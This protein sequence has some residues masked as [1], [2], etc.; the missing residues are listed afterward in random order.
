M[1]DTHME[2]VPYVHIYSTWATHY[3]QGIPTTKIA[4]CTVC[5]SAHQCQATPIYLTSTSCPTLSTTVGEK[6]C[7][8]MKQHQTVKKWSTDKLCQAVWLNRNSIKTCL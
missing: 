2:G 7:L 5:C 6:A 1:P 4:S 3:M 8:W